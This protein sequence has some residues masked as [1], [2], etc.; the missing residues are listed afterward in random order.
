MLSQNI[1]IESD[2]N[3]MAVDNGLVRSE[4]NLHDGTLAF[5]WRDGRAIRGLYG[6]LKV[7][8]DL[9]RTSLYENHSVDEASIQP[10]EDGFGR[11]IRWT[12]KHS[13][14]GKPAIRQHLWSYEGM[15]YVFVE[16]DS[17]QEAEWETNYMSPLAS[18]RN[19]GSVIDFGSGSKGEI[20][21][22]FVPYDN[23][24]WVRYGSHAIPCSVESYEA[25]AI[26]DKDARKGFVL[27]SVTH[28]FWKTGLQV[29]GTWA[30]EVSRLRAFG[31]VTGL[32]TRDTLPH[33]NA[34]GLV[35]VS[36][37]IFV[38]AFDDYRDGM[39]A[40]GRAN[41]VIAPKLP[42]DG[43]VPFGWNSWS[44]VM[45]RLD[46]DVYVH[47][48]DFIKQSLQQ[49]GFSNDGVVYIN[50]DAFWNKLTPEELSESVRRVRAN[51]Q[52]PGIY[53]SP[54]AY[55]GKDPE[56]PVEGFEGYAYRDLLLKDHAGNLL[57]TLDGAYAMDLSHPVTLERIRRELDRF[58]E[59]GFEY[60]K[61][62]FLAHGALEG[63]HHLPDVRSGIQAYHLGMAVIRDTLKPERIGRPFFINVSIAPLFPHGYAHSRRISC[64]AFGL[65]GDTE[66]MLNALTYGW[67]IN[68]TLYR[69]NDPDHT[70]LHKSDNQKE[71]TAHEGRSRLTASVI[72]GTSLLLGDDYRLE[73]AA[74][75]ARSWM[76]RPEVMDLA[77]KGVTF[78]PVEG[79]S[80]NKAED[81]YLLQ[82]EDEAWVA[83]FN[84]DPDHAVSKR[85]ELTRL[86]I[87]SGK[88]V[89]VREIWDGREMRFDDARKA[90]EIEL[91]P[92]ESVLLHFRNQSL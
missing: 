11:G 10:V 29:E 67:W 16:L 73:E 38:G 15:P 50:F 34:R 69:F 65:I 43:G 46:F 86:G 52:K 75:R 63:K 45:G 18:L 27:G 41:A 83:V 64:D 74:A 42:W 51:G 55:W 3:I 71:T 20:R 47:T 44:A 61:A 59:W 53:F 70:V 24:K 14:P 58:V 6:E 54:F 60:V 76:T 80:G 87:Q 88:E 5:H 36:P 49:F 31:G 23:D 89:S 22:L 32:Q 12:F 92:A 4:A 33:G 85:I 8:S 79:T 19:D 62:D 72:A 57:P 48:S 91:Q 66:Y 81:I 77:R 84:F 2:S 13:T 40:F 26:Y 28:D 39:E 21:V 68:D 17:R 82:S 56:R 1:Q 7:G 78:R 25:T 35:N 90:I 9:L 37:R 30:G